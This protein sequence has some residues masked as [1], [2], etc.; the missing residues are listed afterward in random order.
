MNK[1]FRKSW[2]RIPTFPVFGCLMLIPWLGA[3]TVTAAV[4]HG[5]EEAR[6]ESGSQ[7]ALGPVERPPVY[8]DSAPQGDCSPYSFGSE[9][10]P[11]EA[12]PEI[13]R[14]I[15]LNTRARV[16]PSPGHQALPQREPP[17]QIVREPLVLQVTE[18]GLSDG[19]QRLQVEELEL[20]QADTFDLV[21]E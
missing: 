2:N 12:V 18:P 5:T 8:V 21:M 15:Y 16:A 20:R 14:E 10:I 4:D 7:T 13:C 9:D 6:I 1:N 19:F 17:G 3:C 11:L